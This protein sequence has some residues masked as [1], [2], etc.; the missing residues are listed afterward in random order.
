MSEINIGLT[1][2]QRSGLVGLLRV[3]LAD[4][5]VLYTKTRRYHW[6]VEGPNFH[7]LHKLFEG[8]YDA[9]DESIDEIAER[10]RTLGHYSSGSM[11]EFLAEAR[12]QEDSS[13]QI[14]A[15]Q[16]I[17]NLLADHETLVRSLRSD[18]DK[19]HSEFGDAGTQDFFTGLLQDHEK[20]AWML[21]SLLC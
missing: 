21:R 7:D 9:I 17:A 4:E 6:N 15:S 12:L 10:I 3:L 11:K 20:T 16:M 14:P 2:D 18:L 13:A 8:Q 19:A 1:K 5:Y